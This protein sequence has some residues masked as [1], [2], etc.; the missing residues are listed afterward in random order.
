MALGPYVGQDAE[1]SEGP[2]QNLQNAQTR[3]GITSGEIAPA[4]GQLQVGLHGQEAG[5]APFSSEAR[6]GFMYQAKLSPAFLRDMHDHAG[7]RCRGT[8]APEVSVQVAG[9]T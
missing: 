8:I 6:W 4:A 5:C 2:P 7:A 3:I 9:V 1:G